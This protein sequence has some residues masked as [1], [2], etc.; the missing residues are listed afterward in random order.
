MSGRLAG[1]TVLV[2]RDEEADGPLSR[3]LAARGASVVHVPLLETQPPEDS[4]A[5]ER[6]RQRL[7]EYD[8]IFLTSA[9]AVTALAGAGPRNGRPRLAAVGEGTARAAAG[10]GWTAAVVGSGGA[11]ALVAAMSSEGPLEGRSVLFP[12]AD[13]ARSEGVQA[14]E[15]A[16]AR[17]RVV[18]AYRTVARKSAAAELAA[19][20]RRPELDAAT[21]TSPS[22]VEVLAAGG[23]AGLPRGPS[24]PCF[25]AIGPTTRAALEAL[26]IENVVMPDRPDFEALA[27]ALAAALSPG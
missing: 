17:V 2:T 25:A 18:T 3:A 27:D 7:G 10:R 21:F 23:A 5:L 6:E 13:R 14:L 19:V 26:G 8:W 9:R 11:E 15:S 4:E 24:G 12:A 16:G 22:A 1:R 20:L